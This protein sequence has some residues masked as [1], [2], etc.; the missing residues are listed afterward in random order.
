MKKL[1]ILT[2]MFCISIIYGQ[3]KEITSISMEPSEVVSSAVLVFDFTESI[4][5]KY[6]ITNDN[7]EN[8]L[9]KEIE[10]TIGRQILKI[11]LSFLEKGM[12]TIH[13]FND[14][15]EIKMLP[16]KKI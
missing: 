15:N 13:F 9:E 5:L 14:E 6:K 4:F 12:Y 11:D 7:D 10:K 2:A 8:V 1:F 3:E 16:F